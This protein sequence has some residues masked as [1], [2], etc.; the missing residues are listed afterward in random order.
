MSAARAA[1]LTATIDPKFLK[2]GKKAPQL[3]EPLALTWVSRL[4]T[5]RNFGNYQRGIHESSITE[6]VRKVAKGLA[7]S[8][9]DPFREVKVRATWPSL[10]KPKKYGFPPVW[11]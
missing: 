5:P 11:I 2:R 9:I 6:C 7:S 8:G 4:R 10:P 3:C 1:V